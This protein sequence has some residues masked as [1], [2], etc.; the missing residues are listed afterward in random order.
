MIVAIPTFDGFVAPCFEA[1][2]TFV[3]ARV[4]SASIVAKEIVECSG[5]EG[6]GRVQLLRE[7]QVT[8]LICSGIKAFYRDLLRASGVAVVLNIAGDIET[9]LNDFVA[10]KSPVGPPKESPVAL[11]DDA[12][13]ADLVCWSK[14]LFATNGYTVVPGD[15][16][17]P[18]PIDLVA[19]IACP[20]CGRPVRVAICCGAHMYRTDREIQLLHQVGHDFHACVYVRT[21][22]PEIERLCRR[23]GIELIDPDGETKPRRRSAKRIPVLLGAVRDHEEA[24]GAR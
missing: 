10:G 4:E 18:F 12:P 13:L 14:D 15:D 5:C 16:R 9:A 6:F 23:Y 24:S 8:V 11:D 7:R 2:R 1:A 3:L 21:G 22:D 20:R 17:A 19:E